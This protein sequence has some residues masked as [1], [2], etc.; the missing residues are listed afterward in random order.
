MKRKAV[1]SSLVA[2]ST[3]LSA[4]VGCG[5]DFDPGS[6]V[7]S[8]RVLAIQ[9]DNPYAAPGETVR[10]SATSYDPGGRTITWAWAACSNPAS[11]SVEGCL[12]EIAQTTLETGTPPLLATGVGQDSVELTISPSALD[13]LPSE[14]RSNALTG[15]LAV[16]CPGTLELGTSEST[17]GLLPFRCTDESGTELGLHDNIV[18]VKRVFVRSTDRNQNPVIESVTFDGEPWAEGDVK[19]VAGCDTDDF[20]YDDC[21]G[22]LE[23]KVAARL[24]P[25]SF[26]SG[27]DE[28]GRDFS[29]EL[30]VQHYATDGIFEYEVRIGEEPETGWVARQGALGQELRLWFVAHDDRGGVAVA[31]R[32]VVVR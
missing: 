4:L 12:A 32:R 8:F 15:V 31:E 1:L 18:G 24:S 22:S 3:S 5:A 11:A 19:E 9:A 6:N 16:A 10:L 17:G 26:E 7:S 27:V 13:E 2:V 23:H 25:A 21:S 29:E 30:I 20:A 28:Y 14:V